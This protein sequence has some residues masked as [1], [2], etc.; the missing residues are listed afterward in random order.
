MADS[1][2]TNPPSWGS[3]LLSLVNKGVDT[4]AAYGAT[5]LQADAQVKSA[6]AAAIRSDTAAANTVAAGSAAPSAPAGMPAWVKP[7][8]IIGGAGVVLLLVWKLFS[9][10]GRRK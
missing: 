10:G 6:Q 1:T 4:A 9:G 7:V 5:K 3:T 8:A 2:A